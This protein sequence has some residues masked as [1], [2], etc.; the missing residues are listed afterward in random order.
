MSRAYVGERSRRGQGG[1]IYVKDGAAFGLTAGRRI[2]GTIKVDTF[3][4]FCSFVF[5]VYMQ[6]LGYDIR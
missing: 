1:E 4:F 6:P 2:R 5:Y 3:F